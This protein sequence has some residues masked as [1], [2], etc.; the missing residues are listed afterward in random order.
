MARVSKFQATTT[1]AMCFVLCLEQR[2]LLVNY[3][4]E[5]CFNFDSESCTILMSSFQGA[6]IDSE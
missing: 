1:T 4:E 5:R 3:I 6:Q 2:F